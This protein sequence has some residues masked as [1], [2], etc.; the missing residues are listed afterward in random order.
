V[1]NLPKKIVSIRVDEKLHEIINQE[2]QK[3]GIK[4]SEYLREKLAENLKEFENPPTEAEPVETPVEE[5]EEKQDEGELLDDETYRA[6][7]EA[8]K[9]EKTE[10]P[11]QFI[12]INCKHIENKEFN[13]CPQCGAKLKW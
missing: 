8:V 6:I 7:L 9:S 3:K 10:A 5:S 1:R 13:P 12:C 4:T 2:A 11:D